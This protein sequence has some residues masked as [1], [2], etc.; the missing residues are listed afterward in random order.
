MNPGDKCRYINNDNKLSDI[1]EVVEKIVEDG[2]DCYRVK[3]DN[4]EILRLYH[5]R[6]VPVN[7]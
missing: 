6:V 7:R 1:C 2:K 3:L 5:D 4:N